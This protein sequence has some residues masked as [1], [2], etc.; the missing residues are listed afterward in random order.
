MSS[1]WTPSAKITRQ[2]W[3]GWTCYDGFHW[4]G[5]NP[6]YPLTN[7]YL[8]SSLFL[9][10]SVIMELSIRAD[11]WGVKEQ[12]LK[13]WAKHKLLPLHPWKASALVLHLL[14]GF[15][16]SSAQLL[17][18]RKYPVYVWVDIL[19]LVPLVPLTWVSKSGLYALFLITSFTK[20]SLLWG[21]SENVF[22]SFYFFFFLFLVW[23]LFN[24]VLTF[25]CSEV[26]S[27]LVYFILISCRLDGIV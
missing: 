25:I 27:Q 13:N 5:V 1:C 20:N 11:P 21:S 22:L 17:T 14:V 23:L 8:F 4:N 9:F 24:S 7:H 18:G 15:S 2:T 12:A 16:A 10:L 3:G 19:L 6:L 26:I